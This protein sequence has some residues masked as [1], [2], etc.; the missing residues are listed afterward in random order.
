MNDILEAVREAKRRVN[1]RYDN[2]IHKYC[3][4]VRWRQEELKKKGVKYLRLN[5]K[6]EYN[7]AENLV[8]N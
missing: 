6:K 3:F 1:A 2:N 7:P 8:N 4:D 5:N